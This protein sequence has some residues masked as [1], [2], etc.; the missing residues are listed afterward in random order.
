MTELLEKWRPARG[1]RSL[2][3]DI[4]EN[5][6]SL[7]G[8]GNGKRHDGRGISERLVSVV[9][10]SKGRKTRKEREMEKTTSEGMVF[11]LVLVLPPGNL[12]KCLKP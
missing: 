10:V 6:S 1:E 5:Q 12:T 3:S 4:V 11:Y 7:S 2:A 9:P 8:H